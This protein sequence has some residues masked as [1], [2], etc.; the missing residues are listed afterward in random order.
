MTERKRM[1]GF[2]IRLPW[3]VAVIVTAMLAVMLVIAGLASA[4]IVSDNLAHTSVGATTVP[5]EIVEGGPIVDA[6]QLPVTSR[7]L[8]DKTIALTFDDGPDPTWT[9]QVLSILRKH[10]AQGTFF[11]VG[12]RA[13]SHPEL[14]RAIHASGSELAHHTFTHPDLVDVPQ[15]RMDRELDQT[16]LA[17]AGAAGVTSYLFRPPFSSSTGAI[18]DLGYRTVLAAGKRGYVSVFTDADSEDWMLPGVEAIV[19]NSTPAEG[20][21]AVVLMHDSGGDRSQTVAALDKLI[22]QL[23]QDG[24]RFT[25][26]T[27]AVGMAPAGQTAGPGD[28]FSGKVLLGLIAVSLGVVDTLQWILLIVGVLVVARLLLMVVTAYRQARRRRSADWPWGPEAVTTPVTVI[29][30]AYNETANIEVAIRSILA[31]DHPLEVIVVDDGSTDGTADLVEALGLDRV[32]VIRQPNGGKATA[33]NTGIANAVHE[34]IVM[35]DGDTIFERDTVR[36]LVQPFADPKIGAVSGN[37]KIANR[38]TFLTRLQHIEYVVGFNVDRRV[39][40]LMGSMCTIPGAAGA[41]RRTVL[42]DVGGVSQETLAEDTDLTIAIG[43][44]GWRMVY[45]DKAI[46]W[47]EAPVTV[48]QLWQQRYRWTYG[49]MQSVWKHRRAIIERGAGGRLGR[50]GLLHIIA[51]QILMPVTAPLIDVF[52]IYGLFFLNPGTTLV[53]WLSVMLIQTAG[54]AFAF[55]MDG[56]PLGPLWLMPAQ[57]LVYRQ[58]MYVVLGQ[59]LGSAI[60]GVRVRWQRMRRI[61]A[62]DSML[63]AEPEPLLARAKRSAPV[64]TLSSMTQLS[65]G[66]TPKKTAA[67]KVEPPAAPERWLALLAVFALI[68]VALGR[69]TGWGWLALAFPSLG[70]LFALSG[71]YLARSLQLIPAIDAIGHGIR[72]F[73]PS[74][75]LLGIIMIPLMLLNGWIR[76]TDSPLDWPQL[77]LWAFPALDPQVSS[78]GVDASAVLWYVRASLWFVLLTPLLLRALRRSAVLTFLA[79]LALIAADTLLGSPLRDLGPIGEALIDFCT[80]GACWVLGL[81]HRDGLLR[82]LHPLVVAVLSAAA[83]S[84]GTWWAMTHGRGAGV[85]DPGSSPLSQALVSAG[86]V[87][88]LLRLSPGLDWL[89]AAPL[90]GRLVAVIDAR[91]L[92]I[93]LWHSIAFGVAVPVADL[94]TWHSRA[95]VV[96]IGAGLILVAVLAFGWAEDLGARCRPS[97][98]PGARLRAEPKRARVLADTAAYVPKESQAW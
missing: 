19:R 52:F 46:A 31:N 26:V 79:P 64:V 12:S 9:P 72:R 81:A 62:L 77:V 80:F 50:F 39:H 76:D 86:A 95:A 97:F 22:P 55:R 43:R 40:D 69:T 15:W 13:T 45:V 20:K 17:L 85:F 74:L 93:F 60:S 56:E 21:G 59:S 42:L 98:L 47:T 41:F 16:Q 44:A 30:P 61:G 5:P 27:A 29:V 28:E 10:N 58:L 6:T 1:R 94:L 66:E 67:P 90:L 18:D 65:T 8:P 92:T 83:I 35:V 2:R 23:Q 89:G 37:V 53:L 73:L 32:R 11:V 88:L 96:G 48:R 54:A 7:H 91:V 25:T 57:Q 4:G 84:V 3:V 36:Q 33:L 51:F 78:W 14:I 87:L 49:T 24:Y 34:L 71:S 75:W 68:G 82:R 63:R 70:V 38:D